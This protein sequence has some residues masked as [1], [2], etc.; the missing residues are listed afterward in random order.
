M[1]RTTLI[2]S[3]LLA[4]IGA[5]A[6]PTPA[7]VAA[8]VESFYKD[9][10]DVAAKFQQRVTK[11]GRQRALVKE[12]T[13]FF[14]R[15]GM[16]RWDYKS[17]EKVYYVSDGKI[18]WSYDVDSKLVTR[19]D[20]ASSELYHQSRYLFG[21]GNLRDDFDLSQG[22]TSQDPGVK[23]LFALVLKPRKSARN[24]KQL[25]LLVDPATGEIKRTELLDPYDNLSVITF[26]ELAYAPLEVKAF[27]FT[28]PASATIRDLSKPQ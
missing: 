12:G 23:E 9:R 6:A 28:P 16:M 11:P 21:Q 25:S 2:L 3:T 8:K 24:F 17:P 18:L 27:N 14:K 15:P 10:P 22:P 1:I 19:L 20:V 13:A 26:T 4:A 7:D 5:A